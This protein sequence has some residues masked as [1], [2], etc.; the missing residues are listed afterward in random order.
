MFLYYTELKNGR[1][2]TG[3]TS[4]L[5]HWK[6]EELH[7]FAFPASEY[8]LGGL[9]PNE[10]YY[11]WI[12]VACLTELV[13]GA[14]RS[15]WTQA[16][17]ELAKRLILQHNILTEETQGIKSCHVTFHNLI[18]LPDD[19]VCFHLLTTIGVSNLRDLFQNISNNQQ[20]K[21]ILSLPLPKMKYGVSS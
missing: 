1:I 9:L 13:F 8:V 11:I 12:L 10:E 18:H 14:G 4:W 3:L 20:T 16:M 17:L 15:G 5:G 2:P 6:A 19:V 7:K 21:R